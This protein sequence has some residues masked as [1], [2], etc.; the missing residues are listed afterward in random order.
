MQR[1]TFRTSPAFATIWNEESRISSCSPLKLDVLAC[2]S[3]THLDP[4]RFVFQSN[5]TLKNDLQRHKFIGDKGG[6][7]KYQM[8]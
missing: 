5:R 7:E 8:C 4:L 3:V 1:I 2:L 6:K